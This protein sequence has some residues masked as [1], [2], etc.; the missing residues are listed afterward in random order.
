MERDVNRLLILVF[1]LLISGA[2]SIIPASADKMNG[3]GSYGNN[4]GSHPSAKQ[5][6]NF[7]K[8]TGQ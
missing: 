2:L 3:K 6:K 8:K 5:F 1:S 4:A 7:N